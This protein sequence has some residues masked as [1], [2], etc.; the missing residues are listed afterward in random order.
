MLDRDVL[1]RD[2]KN[3]INEVPITVRHKNRQFTA[4]LNATEDIMQTLDGGL[5]D[6]MSISIIAAKGDFGNIP[7]KSMDDF[8][9]LNNGKWNKFQVRNVPDLFDQVSAT[10]TINLQSS[11]KGIE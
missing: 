2:A 10:Y 9:V 11:Q 4:R 8:F 1:A 3:C 5:R 7:P 6:N